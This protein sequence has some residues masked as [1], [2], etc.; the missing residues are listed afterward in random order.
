MT[1]GRRGSDG[2]LLMV[3]G[4]GGRN[5]RHYLMASISSR[6]RMHL[7]LGFEPGWERP[8]LDGW[9]VLPRMGGAI[10]ARAMVAAAQSVAARE[11]VHGVLAWD[12][13]RVVQGAKVAEALGLPGGDRQ[14]VMRCRDKHLTR[15]TLA[16]AG[17]PQARSIV[18]ASTGEA[19]AAAD[20]IGY[21]V[22]LKPR[23]MA[24][25]IGAV[26]ARDPGEL[27]AC[28][29][30]ARDAAGPG[31]WPHDAGVLAEEY[32]TG[33]EI[34]IDA[35]VH[36]GRVHP[37]FV[38]RKEIGYLPYF[39]ETGHLVDAADPLLT[40]PGLHALVQDTH[41]ALG[42]TNGMTHTEVK[43]TPAGPKIIEV[44]ARLGGDLI[45][46][47]G[48]RATGV[49]PGL[50]AAAVACGQPPQVATDRSLV[51][52]IRFFYPDRDDTTID[53]V[54]F[55]TDPPLPATV[56]RAVPL[57]GPGAVV[58]PPPKGTQFG[59]I[60]FAT[61]VAATAQECRAALDAAQAA[62]TVTARDTRHR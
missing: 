4:T 43:L 62:L 28:F 51:G 32:L 33:P 29:T 25:S 36:G 15:E 41:T 39:E 53:S 21:P 12:E 24:A 50:A 42:F 54:S 14:A 9:T 31:A 60:A 16:A 37:L 20:Q 27:A 57:A 23:A 48:L 34:S 38:A 2:P 52:A 13:S 22:V 40:E 47:L 35:A 59:R 45:P 19:R 46:Y 55:A 5:Y 30:F 61:A 6:Y 58:S 8:Y 10:G 18:V 3:V 44:N 26:L 7:L 1:G 49:D 11:P 17:V 56:D